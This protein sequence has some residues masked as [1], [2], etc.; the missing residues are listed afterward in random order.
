MRLSGPANYL[1]FRASIEAEPAGFSSSN[2]V[3]FRPRPRSAATENTA[4]I[5]VYAIMQVSMS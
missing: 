2:V 1:L 5:R 3:R 4:R